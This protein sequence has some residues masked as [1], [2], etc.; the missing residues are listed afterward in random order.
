METNNNHLFM[1]NEIR[2]FEP[3][4]PGGILSEELK[5]RGFS[6]KEFANRIGMQATHLSAI[7]HEKRSITPA[8]A[9]KLESGLDGISADIWVKLQNQYNVDIQRNKVNKSRLVSGYMQRDMKPAAFLAGPGDDETQVTL[10]IPKED[11]ALLESLANR[12]GW[13]IARL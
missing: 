6:Q 10:S 2:P 5:V 3:V 8:V 13:L 1:A 9:T 11:K 12:M 4:H 7:I